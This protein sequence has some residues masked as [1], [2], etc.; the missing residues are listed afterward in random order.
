LLIPDTALP[1]VPDTDKQ[2]FAWDSNE[3]WLLLENKFQK[4]R[5]VGCDGLADQISSDLTRIDSLLIIV[6]SD[7]FSP[8]AP[9]FTEMETAFFELSVVLAACPLR[10]PE[11]ANYYSRLRKSVKNQSAGWDMNAG[12]ARDR[13]YRLLYGC[14]TAIEEI[15]L[16]SLE[17]AIPGVIIETEEPSATPSA[18]ILGVTVHSGDILISRGGAPTSALI[19]RGNDYPGN[20]SHAALLYIDKNTGA[21]S[22][23]ESH[24]EMGVAVAA[25]DDYFR[26]TKLRVMILRLRSDLPAMRSDPMLPHKAA[27]HA[28]QRAFTEHIPYDFTMDTGESSR[29]FCS[30]VVSDAYRHVGIRLWS[31]LSHISS[32]GVKSWLAAFGVKHFT[33]Q[34][35]SDLE[36]DSQIRVVAEWRDHETLYKDHLD[37]AVVDVMLEGAD[38]GDQLDYD[39]YMLPTA[40][41]ARLY[42]MVLNLFGGI[43]PIPEGMN[44]TAALQNE[45][46]SQKHRKIKEQLITS[47]LRFKEQNGY[48][49]PYWALVD[50]AR[51]A[52]ADYR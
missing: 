16:Q 35:P 48:T 49:P 5:A 21:I 20:F 41:I 10:L 44:A 2:P 36:Y 1:P 17:H 3:Y 19:A 23:I 12:P 31:A 40:R 15:I 24:I 42:S 11:Y 9:L 33:T 38:R 50:L 7:T 37:N 6:E 43:G 32:P 27:E 4:A 14:R 25:I 52:A 22:I 26:D 28:L 13:I 51:E 39:W 29:L 45:W 30:E 34:E 8:D 46:F 47:A 18:E